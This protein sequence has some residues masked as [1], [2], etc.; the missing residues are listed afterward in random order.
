MPHSSIPK[1]DALAF[2]AELQGHGLTKEAV[3]VRALAAIPA[4]AAGV[5]GGGMAYAAARRKGED[6]KSDFDREKESAKNP[7]VLR[8]LG[9]RMGDLATENPVLFSL[10]AGGLSAGVGYGAAKK[11][12][13]TY[14]AQGVKPPSPADVGLGK[15]AGRDPLLALYSQD[16]QQ[17]YETLV[18]EATRAD[19]Q[20]FIYSLPEDEL[21]L[22]ADMAH[23]PLV[24]EAVLGRA[25]RAMARP[26]YEGAAKR[27]WQWGGSGLMDIA[28]RDAK[29]AAGL[30]DKARDLSGRASVLRSAGDAAQTARAG[31][32]STKAQATYADAAKR[33]QEAQQRSAVGAATGANGPVLPKIDTTAPQD[34]APAGASSLRGVTGKLW[35]LGVGLG[36][37]VGAGTMLRNQKLK[38]EQEQAAQVEQQEQAKVAELQKEAL[39]GNIGRALARPFLAAGTRRGVGFAA[40][41][42]GQNAAR[43]AAV[44][45]SRGAAA[46][47]RASELAAKAT[48]MEAAGMNAANIRSKAQALKSKADP[49]Q[50]SQF[51]QDA[52]QADAVTGGSYGKGV[53]DAQRAMAPR[54]TRVPVRQAPA[55]PAPA[56]PAP[57]GTPPAPSSGLGNAW[58]AFK[59][60]AKNHLSPKGAF[61]GARDAVSVARNWNDPAMAAL[62]K[63][64]P[65]QFYGGLAGKAA[66]AVGYGAGAYAAGNAVFGGNEKTAAKPPPVT[67]DLTVRLPK[68]YLLPALALGGAFAA[69]R[70]MYPKRPTVP[71]QEMQG[72]GPGGL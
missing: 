33:L 12:F 67:D 19:V 47:A 39:F 53:A 9:N 14:G 6:N 15:T 28:A 23:S 30:M 20:A 65:G 68:K 36:V 37:G 57:T 27:G 56:G 38:Q 44:I 8:R 71:P 32:M 11:G 41:H 64:N 31:T 69:G 13:S 49:R 52:K 1:A 62:R 16:A 72:Y 55:A 22:F 50:L 66:P 10:L 48:R 40:K 2:Y 61:Q 46:S 3:G 70:Y 4:A 35:P 26:I 29:H 54:T 7:G 17:E 18:K 58:D 59:A 45:G 60:N 34:Y 63:N 5:V 51:A 21:A 42:L 25:L 43:S 24:K